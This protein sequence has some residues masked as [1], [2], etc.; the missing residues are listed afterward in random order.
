MGGGGVVAGKGVSLPL[1]AED[2]KRRAVYRG[3]AETKRG[4]SN[5]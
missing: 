3:V 5:R 2:G 4:R 1:G